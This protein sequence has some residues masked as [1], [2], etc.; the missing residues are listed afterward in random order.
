MLAY[1]DIHVVKIYGRDIGSSN[2]ISP[3]VFHFIS[4]IHYTNTIGKKHAS[5]ILPVYVCK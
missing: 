3:I 5:H 1:N 4:I 2:N